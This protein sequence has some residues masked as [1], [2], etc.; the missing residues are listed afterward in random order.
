MSKVNLIYG[1]GDVLHT[2]I[3]INPFAENPDNKKII[4]D[5]IINIDKHVDDAEL[6][7]LVAYD[8]LDYIPLTKAEDAIHNWVKKIRMG[9]KIVLGGTDLI[10]V[11]KSLADYRIDLG[12]ANVLIHG[13]QS[14]P[15]LIK[16]VGFTCL[17]LCDY[18]QNK[19]AFKII[20]KR[21]NNY[22]M[23]VEAERCQ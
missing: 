15:Y 17:G 2:H 9:G 11:C 6:S 22:K 3:N 5:D 8:V 10:E 23:V 12:E 1:T 21:V 20:K 18:L 7:E 16:R 13:E 19:Y 4:R 14:K